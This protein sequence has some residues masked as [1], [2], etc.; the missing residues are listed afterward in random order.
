V[1]IINMDFKIDWYGLDWSGS[2]Q[3]AAEGSLGPMK[4]LES[5]G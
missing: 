1:D 2:G 3:G 4:Y 5:L